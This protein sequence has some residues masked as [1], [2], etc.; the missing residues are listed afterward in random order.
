MS[1]SIF[2]KGSDAFPS[3]HP[4]AWEPKATPVASWNSPHLPRRRDMRNRL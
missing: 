4:F 1:N 2:W 3:L